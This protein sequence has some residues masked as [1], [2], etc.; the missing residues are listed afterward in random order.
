MVNR[1]PAIPPWWAAFF[2]TT[3][4]DDAPTLVP[5]PRSPTAT[6][7]HLP[8]RYLESAP[9]QIAGRT[10]KIVLKQDN[11]GA[12]LFGHVIGAD[13]FDVFMQLLLSSAGLQFS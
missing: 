6:Q 2:S 1:R 10:G 7:E 4:L 5:N 12:G 8:G 9:I 3:L 13:Q 11:T